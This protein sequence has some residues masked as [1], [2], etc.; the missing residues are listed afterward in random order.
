MS[1]GQEQAA[2]AKPAAIDAGERGLRLRNLDEYWRFAQAVVK[3]GLAPKGMERPETVLIAIQMGAE[4]GLLP[5]AAIQNVAV[6]NGRPS[7]W[8]DALLAVARSSGRFDESAFAE[9]AK[10]NFPDDTYEWTCTVRRIGSGVG[11][12]RSYSIADAK[13]AQLWGKAGPWQTYPKRMLQ[14]RARGFAIR[15]A[16]TDFLK[17]FIAAEEAMDLEP[18][19]VRA[20]S[21]PAGV[22]ARL[23]QVAAENAVAP[24]VM[25]SGPELA[26]SLPAESLEPAADAPAPLGDDTH[27]ALFPDQKPARKART[28]HAV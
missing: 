15:D 12:S 27:A 17:G 19:D 3:G 1:D 6:I 8:G 13:R 14:M 10:G 9:S 21:K 11:V 22:A 24:V 4:V 28:G 26:Q 20:E 16:F 7:L 18:I 2:L 5:M 23:Q 25:E